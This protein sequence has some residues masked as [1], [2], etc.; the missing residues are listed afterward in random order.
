M[1][2][3]V[4]MVASQKILKKEVL[5]AGLC[6]GC[7]ACVGLCPYQVMYHD[8]TVQLHPCDL[9]NG[10]CFDFCPRTVT[11]LNSLRNMLFDSHDITPE[12][13]AVKSYCFSRATDPRLR[14]ET[15][16][17][18]T[19]T[20]LAESALLG[21]F[22]D[23]AIISAKDREFAQS[24]LVV[25]DKEGLRKNAGS[26]FTVSPTVAAFNQLTMTENAGNIGAVATPCQSL[27]LAKMKLKAASEDRA[28]IDQP[29]LIIGLYC[30]WTLAAGKL[31]E[32]MSQNDIESGSI[33]GM[34]IPAGKDSLAIHTASG[35]KLFP[36]TDIQACIRSACHYCFD[37]T[38]EYADISVG[39]A[40]FGDDGDEMRR[41]NQMI[42]RTQKGADL[43]ESAIKRGA[44]EVK[45]APPESLLQLKKAAVQK[46]KAALQNIIRKSGSAKNLLYLDCHDP[47][48][49]EYLAVQKKRAGQKKY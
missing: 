31:N 37:S 42:V 27:A 6:T 2:K 20:A 35:T 43:I 22:I 45:D 32:L 14:E 10:K 34:D 1:I 36:L 4:M 16:H 28:N 41:W 19:V 29:K 46:K 13:G 38:A 44:L 18:G 3:S 33:Y 40:R 21:G 5:E 30:G 15:Q 47:M 17:G 7:G 48:V 9:E 49:Q 12:I 39:A 24:G 11:D 8:R 26:R 25:K 23:S